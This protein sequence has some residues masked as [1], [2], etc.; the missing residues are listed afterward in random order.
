MTDPIPPLS[1]SP[2]TRVRL[3]E[4]F[5]LFSDQWSPKIVG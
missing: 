4:K 2:V 5:K 1:N 3:A